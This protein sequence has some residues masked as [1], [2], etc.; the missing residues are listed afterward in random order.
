MWLTHARNGGV[1]MRI[2]RKPW[3]GDTVVGRKVDATAKVVDVTGE[4][5][6]VTP[7]G[8]YLI[9]DA[10]GYEHHIMP[11]LVIVVEKGSYRKDREKRGYERCKI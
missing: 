9:M 5:L 11:H 6:G 4:L 3:V 10:Q 7:D 1:D 2:T 8:N